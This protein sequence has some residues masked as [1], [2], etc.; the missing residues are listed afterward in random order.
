MDKISIAKIVQGTVIDHIEAG[1]AIRIYEMLNLHKHSETMTLG[2][3]LP[4]HKMGEKDLIKVEN[5]FFTPAELSSIALLAPRATISIIEKSQVSNKFSVPLPE[6]I[7]GL[8][9][10]PN[11]NCISH[12]E[13][14]LNRFKILH[15]FKEI[16][17]ECFYCQG[18]FKPHV[19]NESAHS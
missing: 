4:S 18:A 16:E 13:T 17:L 12:K 1:T 7:Q 14:P 15:R 10:C 19:N 5:R 9:T 11:A 6:E 3:R 2:I 8:F